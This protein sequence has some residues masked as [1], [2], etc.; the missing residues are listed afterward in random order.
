ME[1]FEQFGLTIS[2]KKCELEPKQELVFLGWTWNSATMELYM[3]EDRKS[4]NL[5]LLKRLVKTT[6]GNHMTRVKYLA[7]IIGTLSFLRTQFREASLYL[8]L[9]Y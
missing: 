8:M 3:P 7:A 1:I 9:L 2:L 4:T 6:L 5:D